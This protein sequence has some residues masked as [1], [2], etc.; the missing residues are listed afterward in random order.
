M[1]KTLIKSA[2]FLAVIF[3]YSS[4]ATL[5]N[6]TVLKNQCKR[7][8]VVDVATQ[9][10]VHVEEGC[11]GQNT[12]LEEKAKVYAYDHNQYERAFKYK[13]KCK[14]WKKEQ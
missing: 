2:L 13:V 14:S 6:G 10:V 11:G 12:R 1:K 5:F 9:E 7:C 3:L 8:E 4:C